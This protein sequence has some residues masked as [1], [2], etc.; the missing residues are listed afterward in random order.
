MPSPGAGQLNKQITIQQRATTKDAEGG[1]VD[2]WSDFAA[3]IWAKKNNLS[4]NERQATQQGGQRLEA[5]T[6]YTVYYIEG[7]NNEMRIVD[8]G[9]KYNIRHVNNYMENNEFLIITCD[10]GG[11]NGR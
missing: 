9:V 3:D 10:T 2:V 4:G 5:R 7:V 8:N 11:N 6:E 1:M